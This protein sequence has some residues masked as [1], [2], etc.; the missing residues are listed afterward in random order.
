MIEAWFLSH[1]HKRRTKVGVF[2]AATQMRKQ[3]IPL[4]VALFTLT[5]P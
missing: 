4:E 1:W 2:N 3:G 5:R